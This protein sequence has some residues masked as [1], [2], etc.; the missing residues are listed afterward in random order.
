MT[1]APAARRRLVFVPTADDARSASPEGLPVVLDTAWTP[2]PEDGSDLVCLR[3]YFA[4]VVER[5]DL[6]REA[7]DVVDRWAEASGVADLLVVEEM[8]YWAR[9]REPMW[10]WVHERLLWRHTLAAFDADDP[11][12]AVSVPRAEE[13][14][15][16]VLR[17][18]GRSIELQGSPARREV[19]A[20]GG[21]RRRAGGTFLSALRR[22]G[23][24]IVPGAGS[25][26]AAERRRR[27]AALG[28][29]FERL[30]QLPAPRVIVLTLPSSYQRI[31]AGDHED[32]RDPN[33]GSVIPA[34]AEAG[35]EPIAIGWNM[36]ARSEED[37]AAVERDDRLLP[38]HFLPSRWGRPEDLARA[39]SATSSVLEKLTGASS[40]P[41]ALDGLDMTLAFMETIRMSLQRI[42]NGE[43]R[44]LARVERLIKEVEPSAM[45][46]TQEHHRTP[47][48]LAA[49]RAGVPTF[50]LQ[51]GVLYPAHPG[52]PHQRYPGIVLPTLT[53]VFGEYERRV[54]EG[55]VYRPD[56]VAVAGSPRLDLDAA[57]SSA[58]DR[59]AER[60]AVRSELGVADGD[61]M[62]VVS[63]VHAPFVRRSH[64]VHMLEVLL[65]GP[66]PGVHVVFKQ[67]PGE[68]DEGPYR[69]LL[70]GLARAGGYAEPP[71]TI[72]RD[73]DLYR[74]L[75]AA[76]AHLGLQSTVLTDAV[77]AG[78]CNLIAV[79]EANADILGYVAAGVARPVR[80]AADLLRALGERRLPSR[81]AREAF[82]DDHFRRGEASRRIAA[83]IG[84]TVRGAAHDAE[85]TAR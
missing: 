38:S 19:P 69:R 74:L 67:H 47:W 66:L 25:G 51:H 11:Y 37:W 42:V 7:L 2:E 33:L 41:L 63:T 29:R 71:I 52:Y 58:A 36:D 68:R 21:A 62:L 39:T 3:P 22:W 81:E 57:V 18:L 85:V 83:T 14:L 27:V 43:V 9:V 55:G 75:R 32:R 10:H 76:D 30:A 31:G 77:V 60:A 54:L 84:A 44:E 70:V 12:D 6:S 5:H 48:L 72:V 40:V 4:A 49:S 79:V 13:A 1:S 17:A 80:D 53:F 59:A 64:L 8:S 61:L 65:G 15:I 82:I 35:L 50:A 20:S 16:D 34:L 23:R 24:R 45:L 78:T 28:A 73:V 26:A 56:E 46:L